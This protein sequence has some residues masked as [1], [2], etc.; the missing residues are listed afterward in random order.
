ML[1]LADCKFSHPSS[2]VAPKPRGSYTSRGSGRRPAAV[3]N[4]ATTGMNKSKK[5]GEK[6]DP[7]A[8]AFVP[9]D[10]TAELSVE[11]KTEVE[12]S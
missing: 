8:G 4:V 1:M 9:K 2:R 5:F 10:T 3:D 6:L 7:S 12:T 11:Q